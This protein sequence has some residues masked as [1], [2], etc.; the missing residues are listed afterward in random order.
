[1]RPAFGYFAVFQSQDLVGALDGGAL[2]GDDNGGFRS[3]DRL[4]S[5]K[6]P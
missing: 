3:K 5:P 6:K 4:R 1:M 2:V